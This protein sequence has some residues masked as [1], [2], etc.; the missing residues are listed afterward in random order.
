MTTRSPQ[1][2][3]GIRLHNT[4]PNELILQ[5]HTTSFII[6]FGTDTKRVFYEIKNELL[7]GEPFNII[8]IMICYEISG[9]QLCQ[10]IDFISSFFYS[11]LS[12]LRSQIPKL[13]K[14][15]KHIDLIRKFFNE[16]TLI[17]HM[18][19]PVSMFELE[20]HKTRVSFIGKSSKAVSSSIRAKFEEYG[21][22][23]GDSCSQIATALSKMSI[24]APVPALVQPKPD[25]VWTQRQMKRS[26]ETQTQTQSTDSSES[27]TQ[28]QPVLISAK[29]TQ[30]DD[31]FAQLML[32]NA[33]LKEEIT[34][35]QELLKD[36]SSDLKRKI[37]QLE[38]RLT[39]TELKPEEIPFTLEDH[40]RFMKEQR[41][42]F[43]KEKAKLQDKINLLRDMNKK[44]IENGRVEL[45]EFK[46]N[47]TE[48]F[49]KQL[50]T[51]L[52]EYPITPSEIGHIL[53][54]SNPDDMIGPL[55]SWSMNIIIEKYNKQ[56]ETGEHF[57]P[58]RFFEFWTQCVLPRI[59]ELSP[60]IL[61]TLKDEWARFRSMCWSSKG[62]DKF[63]LQVNI[64]FTQYIQD[65][66]N[67]KYDG[68]VVPFF[69]ILNHSCKNLIILV[70]LID[71]H[72]GENLTPTVVDTIYEKFICLMTLP[73]PLA[74]LKEIIDLSKRKLAEA[75][76]NPHPMPPMF[77]DL[78]FGI[79]LPS[80]SF[81]ETLAE[82]L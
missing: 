38:K 52:S 67:K 73:E 33:G 81:F 21:A 22:F 79:E 47:S 32:E 17:Q 2:I 31:S 72:H 40:A 35:L 36:N 23:L 20:A 16:P 7:K 45:K 50:V 25:N 18:V 10:N 27:A 61:H 51:I 6:S 3:N 49:R 1:T 54:I 56:I 68:Y 55:S 11:I 62:E 46:N 41:E 57:A 48:Y 37:S 63:A 59:D 74:V 80:P 26:S 70:I 39:K 44:V 60:Q 14:Y 64:V 13:I 19:V 76:E 12:H 58:S 30:T 8:L 75:D 82:S 71:Q 77:N 53:K 28:T 65:Y 43:E 24:Q 42:I 29:T 34:R 4:R 78:V 66:K 69:N 9:H 5:V 15:H